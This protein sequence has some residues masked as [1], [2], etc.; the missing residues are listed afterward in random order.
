L[1]PRGPLYYV[2]G[3]SIG[4]SLVRPSRATLGPRVPLWVKAFR[5][6]LGRLSQ[7]LGGHFGL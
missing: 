2:L 6:H 5:G 7:V 3:Y 1:G 4:T